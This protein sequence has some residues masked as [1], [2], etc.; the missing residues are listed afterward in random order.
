MG[1]G[2]ALLVLGCYPIFDRVATDLF[3]KRGDRLSRTFW[4]NVTGIPTPSGSVEIEPRQTRSGLTVYEAPYSRFD[5]PLPTTPYFN[6][7]LELRQPP[8]FQG[9]F[10]N[11]SPGLYPLYGYRPDIG[12]SQPDQ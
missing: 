10:R 2:L 7:Y 12:T 1:A 3:Y 9:G 8:G 6:R 5:F 4:V 11:V